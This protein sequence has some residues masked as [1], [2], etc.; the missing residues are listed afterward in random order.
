MG[1]TEA[2]VRSDIE[3]L[4]TQAVAERDAADLSVERWRKLLEHFDGEP[5]TTKPKAKRNG[6]RPGRLPSVDYAEVARVYRDLVSRGLP[7]RQGLAEHFDR[8]LTTVKN[9]VST[10]RKQG[11]NLTPD[12][13]RPSPGAHLERE[14]ERGPGYDGDLDPD[15]AGEDVATMNGHLRA[16]P[17][18]QVD[19]KHF[20]CS[21]CDADETSIPALIKHTVSAHDR[22]PHGHERRPIGGDGRAVHHEAS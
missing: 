9:W 13:T 20:E 11:H 4:L 7:V 5:T 19:G 22:S 15:V 6:T 2:D 3:D 10:C 1:A 17:L 18:P 8:P 16:N 21:D 12:K 14:R